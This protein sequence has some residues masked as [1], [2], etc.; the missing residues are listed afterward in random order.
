VSLDRHILV[1]QFGYRP[2]DSKIAV[3]RSPQSGFD[4]DD[5]FT[6]GPLYEVRRAV[7]GAVVS[8]GAPARWNDGGVQESSGDRGWWFDF[9]DVKA[10]GKYFITDSKLGVRSPV[11][12][13]DAHVYRDV[14]KAATRMF[15]YQR[16]GFAKHPP[17]AESC[18]ADEPA[19]TGPRQ[20]TEA[21]DVT[22]RDNAA[23][24]R[25]VSGG[26]FDAGDTNKYV[27]AAVPAVHQLLSAYE[28]SPQA[29]TDD[30][31]IPE[32]GNGI[33]DVLDEV[34]WEITWLKKMQGPDGS[35]ALK[36][37]ETIIARA[38]PP[39]S[40]HTPRYYIPACSSATISVAGM[41][42]H[43][44]YVFR[45]VPQ[46]ATEATELQARA[47]A[48]WR[49]F[50]H[51][52]IDEHCDTGVVRAG[53]ADRS[54]EQQRAAAVVAAIYLYALTRAGE[55]DEY[56]HAHYREAAPFHKS[57]WSRYDPE[58]GDALLSYTALP[59]AEPH[60]RAEILAAKHDDVLAS[61]L[62]YG[63]RAEDDLYR[64]FLHREQYHWGSNQVRANYGNSNLDVGRYPV[65]IADAAGYDARALETLHYFHGVNPFGIVYLTNMRAYGATQSVNELFHVWFARYPSRTSARLDALKQRL[66][67]DRIGALDRLL[68]FHS[69][70]N[71]ALTSECGPAPG[72][73]P[74]GPNRNV[75][76]NGVP[77]ALQPPSRQPAQKSYRDYNEDWPGDS[78]TVNEPG[79]YYQSAYIKLLAAFVR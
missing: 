58:Q 1:D 10:P 37:G 74:G 45:S 48:A 17:Y 67:L 46:L 47:T 57:G 15:F 29:F 3:I 20:D 63:F 11:F 18:W 77:A 5:P 68:D 22:D 24:V 33:P 70:W 8:R 79:I 27:T 12:R 60:L 40:D 7:D 53:N 39:S 35:A 21:R 38:S 6:P 52:T 14:L 42:A 76:E 31:G 50:A 64:A 54:A 36:V 71:D 51:S 44:A 4:A 62:V 43:A 61:A 34:D 25:D 59:G 28:Q 78:W 2:E 32:S 30:F 49:N 41:F 16:S 75:A 55:F 19:Y 23:K 69:R 72:Y 56:L 26:W 65:D 13:I 66:S 73:L 9:S